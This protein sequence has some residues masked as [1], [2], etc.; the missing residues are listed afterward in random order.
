MRRREFIFTLPAAAV[1]GRTGSV[2]PPFEFTNAGGTNESLVR[3]RGKTVALYFFNP[4]CSHCLSVCQ[5]LVG[6]QEQMSSDVQVLGVAFTEDAARRMPDF[7]TKINPN[8]P[9]GISSRDAV[10]AFLGVKIPEGN[11]MPRL[12]LIDAQGI[13]RRSYGWQDAIF[14]DEAS[15]ESKIFSAVR[16]VS[17]RGKSA[18]RPGGR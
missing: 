5:L 7:Q 15:Q 8:Y 13:L 12:I 18:K 10:L 2:A 9:V 17:S 14:Q 3:Y 4:G 11:E 16:E 6:V 1:A